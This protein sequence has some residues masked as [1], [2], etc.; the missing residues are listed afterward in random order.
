MVNFLSLFNS[1][2]PLSAADFEDLMP[3]A[4][5]SSIIEKNKYSRLVTREKFEN[6]FGSI[7]YNNIAAGFV[8]NPPL[9]TG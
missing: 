5:C 2:I 8:K 4:F 6:K 3:I 1:S 7:K 9:S